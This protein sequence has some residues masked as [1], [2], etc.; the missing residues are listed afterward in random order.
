V[1]GNADGYLKVGDMHY[2]GMGGLS[3]SK[4][5]AALYYQMAADMHHTHAMFNLGFM[6][7]AGDGVNQDFHLAKRYYDQ[8]AEFDKEAH[9][10]IFLAVSF[11]QVPPL[12][13]LSCVLT[14]DSLPLLRSTDP[15]RAPSERSLRIASGRYC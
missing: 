5:N 2:Y 9:L 12:P 11:L 1:L 14:S 3:P 4:K 6:H 15:S 13:S 7:E 10:P 8:V